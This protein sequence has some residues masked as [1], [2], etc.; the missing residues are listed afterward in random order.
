MKSRSWKKL[1]IVLVA[2]SIVAIAAAIIIPKLLDPNEYRGL[3]ISELEKAVG[4]QVDIGHI[5]WGLGH[6][7]SFKVDGF[8][9]RGASA[10]PVDLELSRIYAKVSIIPLL[11]KSV[12]VK[13]LQLDEPNVIVRLN[14]TSPEGK[15]SKALEDTTSSTGDTRP[16]GS[17]LPVAIMIRELAIHKG[18][19]IVEDALTLSGQKVVRELTDVELTATNLSPGEEMTFQVRLQDKAESGLGILKIQGKFAGLTQIL[20]LENPQLNME[21]TLS[22]LDMDT[23]KPYL[24]N[25]SLNQKLGG[26]VSLEVNYEGDFG[27]RFRV[28]GLIDGSKLTYTDPSLW[29]R[30]LPGVETKIRYQLAVDPE[31]LTVEKLELNWGN[32]T[33]NA[34]AY[35]ADWLTKPVIK[36]AAISSNWVMADL[37][38]LV[39]WRKLGKNED[40]IR[41]VLEGG[42]K[43]TLENVSLPQLDLQK[44]PKNTR[45]MMSN[46]KGALEFS[47]INVQPSPLLPKIEG[48]TGRLT[49]ENGVLRATKIHA[50]MGPLTLPTID[51]QA[52]NLLGHPALSAKVKGQLLLDAA[53]ETEVKNLLRDH[54][55][56]SLSGIAKIDMNMHYDQAKPQQWQARGSLVLE[57]IRAETHPAKVVLN[58][59]RGRVLFRRT[60]TVEIKVENLAGK[61]NQ[62]PFRLHGR[63]L[64]SQ[65]PDLLIDLKGQAQQLD[66][67]Q[68]SALVPAIKDWKLGGKLDMDVDIYLPYADPMKSR[69]KGILR[70][71]DLGFRLAQQNVIVKDGDANLQFAGNSVE[72][73]NLTLRVNDQQLSIAGKVTHPA[74][75]KLQLV[76]KS[77]H[78]DL[79]LLLPTSVA[80]KQPSKTTQQKK[81]AKKPKTSAEKKSD[82]LELPAMARN[83][84]AWL[85]VAA[86]KGKY[87][88][89]TFSDLK[90]KVYYQNGVLKSHNFDVRIA[91]GRIQ[92]KGSA[93]LRNL[94]QIPFVV[95]PAISTV[96]LESLAPLFRMNNPPG[97][98]SFTMNGNLRGR[99]G[100]AK[101]L[102]G[103]IRGQL[104][105]EV[106]RGRINKLSTA[107]NLFAQIFSL[108][109]VKGILSGGLL[110]DWSDEGLP[111]EHL[112]TSLVFKDGT[113]NVS[114]F[115]FKSNA[116]NATSNGAVDLVN[117]QLNMRAELE[118]L[119]TLDK[120][121]GLIPVFGKS[122][123]KLT[124]IYLSLEGSVSKP[125][126]G[127]LPAKG[128]TGAAGKAVESSGEVVKRP[129][130]SLGKGLEK[131]FNK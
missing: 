123:Q 104:D 97:K 113:M 23:V 100:S 122:G 51:F 127:F 1:I 60:K 26:T 114:N 112:K 35:V 6:G 129:L 11:T 46:I 117:Q 105:A 45:S 91:G 66:L 106:N 67:A 101:E 107:G 41:N 89:Q 68:L 130:D 126:I 103:S 10:M 53:G 120:V 49:L 15:T 75:P 64:G 24:G 8:S 82:K 44:L 102:L 55:L 131:L 39:P 48:I 21:A 88:G 93:D 38:P 20:T 65:T 12:V 54:G 32:L 7:I 42:G 116:L 96:Q 52:S 115:D 110:D 5:S 13:K 94:K 90:L 84:T 99:T 22:A 34:Q 80:E 111:F 81:S 43:V 77:P 56:A 17:P 109:S 16:A 85:N 4:G 9:I 125:K 63:V 73:Q 92:T 37:I 58:E 128:F 31:R 28:N 3:I 98:G 62:S 50:K 121:M 124:K 40:I 79:D 30:A 83:G 69:L 76:V 70:T 78:L 57:G 87:Q 72:V 108:I 27:Q 71:R 19:I 2:L 61:V 118:L 59:L 25:N 47:D 95:E 33:L 18:Q 119:G 36:N 86:K 29:E 74:K 14:P